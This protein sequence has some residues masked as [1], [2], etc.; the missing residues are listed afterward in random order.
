MH[1]KVSR[2]EQKVVGICNAELKEPRRVPQKVTDDL[3]ERGRTTMR[4]LLVVIRDE[5]QEV[6]NPPSS[7]QTETDKTT[8]TGSI[9]SVLHGTK[10]V[11]SG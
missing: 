6:T 2:G 7:R 11:S 1:K 9:F 8:D 4:L 5:L 3:A 10:R